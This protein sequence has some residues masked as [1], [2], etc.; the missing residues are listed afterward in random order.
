MEGTYVSYAS[1][2]SVLGN[3]GIDGT[4]NRGLKRRHDKLK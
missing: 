4:E 3:N 2:L 1:R